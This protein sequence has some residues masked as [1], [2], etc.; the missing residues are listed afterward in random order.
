MM[1]LID[2]VKV[3]PDPSLYKL[4]KNQK[5]QLI[6]SSIDPNSNKGLV[7]TY[8]LSHS[9]R[10]INNRVYS[11][12]GQQNGIK[13]L[14][15]PYP[16]PI[17]LNHD[18]SRDPIGR[19]IGGEWQDL[20]NQAISHFSNV[21]S[22]MEFKN[23]MMSNDTEKMYH[24]MK[25]NNLL[26]NKNWPGLG[27]M[28][29]SAK[30]NDQEAIEKFLD[31][32][33]ITFSAGST[34]NQHICSICNSD[35]AKDGLCEHRHGRIYDGETCVFFTG[36]FMVLEGSVVNTPA[37]DLSQV[38]SMEFLS[39]SN[40]I[41]FNTNE[42]ELDDSYIIFSDSIMKF[43]EEVSMEN[44]ETSV[45]EEVLADAIETEVTEVTAEVDSATEE[46]ELTDSQLEQIFKYVSEKMKQDFDGD[47]NAKEI[48][49]E[50]T[51][52]VLEAENKEEDAAEDSVSSDGTEVSRIQADVQNDEENKEE[53]IE[54]SSVE[55]DWYL[56]DAALS[57][58]V[59][60]KMLTTEERKNLPDSAFCGP[61]RSFPVP[62]CAHVTAARR[63]IG[64]AKLSDSQK[65]KVL[66]CVNK[67]AE[68][69]KCD[70]EMEDKLNALNEKFK[71][72]L[73][74]IKSRLE[75][76]SDEKVEVVEEV[77]VED[78]LKTVENPS[79]GTSDESS[80]TEL[81]NTQ[82]LGSYEQQIVTN[83]SKILNDNG[84]VAAEEYFTAKARY[85]PKGFH[86]KKY[87]S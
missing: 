31:G 68:G 38:Q 25:K 69:M 24:A 75:G 74:E 20:S 11:L 16:K 10:R 62:D 52:E 39:D 2:Y 51:K 4:S 76:L 5:I 84:E 32:R 67:K 66:S 23:T 17:L 22:F 43:N 57:T 34:T 79:V 45:N 21:N 41:S 72:E 61:E 63:L 37:D 50:D 86:P 44:K 60:D 58:E 6:D 1:K 26:L 65:Q 87:L 64:R 19:F 56:L 14:L 8:D 46:K 36:D 30:I 35:W 83:Y 42:I 13:S 81:K 48:E 7:V 29:V 40:N 28:R 49:S 77:A 54:D 73:S 70:S 15:Q 78:T 12:A 85:T 27:R 53:V 47:L 59:A 33:Y 71:K 80:P 55:V 18:T 3:A 82:K 9:A